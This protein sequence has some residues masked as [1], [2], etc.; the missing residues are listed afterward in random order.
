MAIMRHSIIFGGVDSA[1]YGIYISGEGVFN[2]PRRDVE[3]AAIP[4]RNGD[5]ALDHG[6]Y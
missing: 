2:A 4:G 3:M 1:D 6:R 5:L